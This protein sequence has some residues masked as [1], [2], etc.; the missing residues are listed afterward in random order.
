MFNLPAE[1]WWLFAGAS[2]LFLSPLAV[3]YAAVRVL[4]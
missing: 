4:R 1:I 2:A 3:I